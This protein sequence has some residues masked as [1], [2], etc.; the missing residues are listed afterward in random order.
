M[1]SR[2][3]EIKKRLEQFRKS[4]SAILRTIAKRH[5]RLN[6]RR[7]ALHVRAG[8]PATPPRVGDGTARKA[9]QPRMI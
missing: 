8:E 7:N 9:D 1:S 3:N 5:E 4:D 2:A 6:A